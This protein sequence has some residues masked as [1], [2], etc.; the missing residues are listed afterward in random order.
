MTL[1]GSPSSRTGCKSH[2]RSTVLDSFPSLGENNNIIAG[3]FGGLLHGSKCHGFLA[4]LALA[5]QILHL[6]KE[7]VRAVRGT[8]TTKELGRISSSRS[9]GGEATGD[10]GKGSDEGATVCS[11]TNAATSHREQCHCHR[12]DAHRYKVDET[13]S[14][15]GICVDVDVAPHYSSGA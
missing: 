6:G 5:L 3:R 7:S 8:S 10:G 1:N 12:R 9:R 4:P 13:E 11:V 14:F 15:R 2:P